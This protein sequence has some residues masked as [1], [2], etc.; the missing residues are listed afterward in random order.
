MKRSLRM[1]PLSDAGA[2]AGDRLA[3]SGL[4]VRASRFFFQ[5]LPAD[6]VDFPILL[7]VTHPD[8]MTTRSWREGPRHFPML[9][10]PDAEVSVP[11]T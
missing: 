5:P 4:S 10:T 8:T 1:G 2:S 11:S 7:L 9:S 3:S 6:A